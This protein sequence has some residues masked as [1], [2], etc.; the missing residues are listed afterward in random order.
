MLPITNHHP[1]SP[2]FKKRQIEDTKQLLP[3]NKSTIK[4]T[5]QQQPSNIFVLTLL[6]TNY[7]YC[8]P[9]PNN[10]LSQTACKFYDSP[11]AT[12]K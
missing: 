1:D 12:S 10:Y 9:K 6:P 5:T 8:N 7:W 11:A 3:K 2:A 4:T